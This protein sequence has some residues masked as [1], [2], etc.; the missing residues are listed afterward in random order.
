MPCNSDYMEPRPGETLSRETAKLIVYVNDKRGIPTSDW[1]A[2]AAD[3]YYGAENRVHDLVAI[4]CAFIRNMSPVE[5]S[6]IVYNGRDATARKLAD[7]WDDHQK[8]DAIRE[9]VK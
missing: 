9:A 1:I 2:A 4:L 6:D 8:A 5:L 7:W 3:E